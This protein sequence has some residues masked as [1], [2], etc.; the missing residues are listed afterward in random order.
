[1][2]RSRSQ[3]LRQELSVITDSGVRHAQQLDRTICSTRSV[4]RHP[5]EV[6]SNYLTGVKLVDSSSD[7]V[8]DARTRTDGGRKRG[9][10]AGPEK[11]RW[12]RR[13]RG[14][15]GRHIASILQSSH[16]RTHQRGINTPTLRT[17]GREDV[18]RLRGRWLKD[19][20]LLLLAAPTLRLRSATILNI[21]KAITIKNCIPWE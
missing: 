13:R 2:S 18:R 16:W 9:R 19:T 17:P 12:R 15:G 21:G 3:W 6:V 8:Y 20:K 1:M 14:R 11:V 4:P 10:H 7:Y 5:V